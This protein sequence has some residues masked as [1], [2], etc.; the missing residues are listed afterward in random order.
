MEKAYYYWVLIENILKDGSVS[1]H[2]DYGS[3]VSLLKMNSHIGPFMKGIGSMGDT[4]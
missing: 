2:S 4:V 1:F 3:N